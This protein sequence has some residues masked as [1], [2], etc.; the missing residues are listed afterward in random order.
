MRA[1]LVLAVAVCIASFAHA[2]PVD[3]AEAWKPMV[4][5]IGTW[6]GTRAGA[7]KPVRLTRVFAS[8]PVN[9]HLEITESG[10]GR[11]GDALTAT[12][13]L[14]P[15]R[16]VLVL[17]QLAGDGPAVD[18]A[19]DDAASSAGKLVF[20]SEQAPRVRITYERADAR[21][22]TERVERASGSDAFALVTETQFVRSN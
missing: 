1:A 5:F 10:G 21:H 4:S 9:Q 15:Q 13:T 18:A 6:K 7:E 19:L 12:V 17:H 14:D 22:F 8:S 11:R 20:E 2:A 3:P 16:E